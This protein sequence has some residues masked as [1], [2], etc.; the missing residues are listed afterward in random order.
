MVRRFESEKIEKVFGYSPLPTPPPLSPHPLFPPIFT[1]LPS[2]ISHHS[3]IY[4][5]PPGFL[6]RSVSHLPLFHTE[7]WIKWARIFKRGGGGGFPSY[8]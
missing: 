5:P 7:V 8:L 3:M 4:P 6:L 2:A 1:S